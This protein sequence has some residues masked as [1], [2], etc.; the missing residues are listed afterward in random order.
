MSGQPHP[1]DRYGNSD[2]DFVKDTVASNPLFRERIHVVPN[3]APDFAKVLIPACH[4][5]LNTPKVGDEACGTSGMKAGEGGA[6]PVTTIDG[7]NAELPKDILY[8]IE[9]ETDSEEE[10]SSLYQQLGNAV[11]D[12]QD[13]GKW[14][15][16]VKRY[17]KGNPRNHQSGLHIASGARMLASYI[18]LALPRKDA[19]TPDVYSR[20]IH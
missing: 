3:W 6:L 13:I 4:V 19:F 12:A 16:A 2:F 9:G 10:F 11:S 8:A 5:W 7:F 18:N 1:D 14:S 20:R 15:E 17:W